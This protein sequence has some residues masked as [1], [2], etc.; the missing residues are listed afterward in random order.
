M[1]EHPERIGKYEILGK[2][3]VGGFGVVYKGWDPY[4]KRP[5][6]IKTCAT[7]DAE[8]RKRFFREAQFVGNLVHPNITL[9]FDFG[10][11]NEIPYIVQE[12]LTGYDVDQ[13]LSSGVIVDYRAICSIMIQACDGLDFAHAR[14]VVHRDIKPSNMRLLEDGVVKIMDFGIAKSLDSGS[15]LTQTGIALGTAGYLSPEQIQGAEIDARTDIFALGI[16]AYELVT[17]SRPF[18]GKSLSNVLYKILNEDPPTPTSVRADCPPALEAVVLKAMRKPP[19]ERFQTA[20]EM[21][22][23][24]RAIEIAPSGD[25][26]DAVDDETTGILR[27]IVNRM[28]KTHPPKRSKHAATD[29]DRTP[30][31]GTEPETA[32]EAKATPTPPQPRSE[33]PSGSVESESGVSPY[34]IGGDELEEDDHRRSPVL[35]IFVILLLLVATAAGVIFLSPDAQRLLFGPQ[36]APWVTTPTPTPTATPTATPVP[37]ATPTPGITAT[38]TPAPT[39]TPTPRP[40]VTFTLFV[41]PPANVAVNGR[42]LGEGKIVTR[43]VTL[44]AG[45]HRFTASLPGVPERTF[46]ETISPGQE[47]VRLALDIGLLTVT[48][49]VGA[50]TGAMAVLDGDELGPVPI[51]NAKVEVGDHM[52]T[53]RWPEDSGHR[54]YTTMVTVR[55]MGSPAAVVVAR[56]GE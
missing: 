35:L 12:Y 38:P 7:P 50:P 25:A 44:P 47:M 13:M 8:V 27:S 6:A 53:V 4:I 22:E 46:T 56:P 1:A 39:A 49:D 55:P 43:K 14:G 11:E 32:P 52:L 17:S 28:E 30:A 2:I 29:P 15:K 23:A 3:G 16:L 42:S 10:V 26:E 45:R 37:T 31:A 40:Q 51:T 20:R 54:P 19:E 5:V 48:Y 21:A 18:S 33:A 24:I 34:T 9:V 36:G 41:D